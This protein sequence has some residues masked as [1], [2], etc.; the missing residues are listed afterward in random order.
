MPDHPLPATLVTTRL[1]RP[2]HEDEFAR[3]ADRFDEAACRGPGTEGSLRLEQPGGMHHFVHRFPSRPELDRWLG[4]ED[5]R[6]LAAEADRYSV[7]RGEVAEGERRRASLPSEAAVPKWKTWVATWV[8]VF[9][10]LLALNAAVGVA[11]GGLPE[12]V[13]LAITSLV[14]TAALT[15]FLLPRIKKWLR[16]WLFADVADRSGSQS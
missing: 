12:P 16:P 1:V 7:G 10:L 6:A 11:A 15:W 9:P 5:Y 8:T 4:G 2:G 3:W 13:R 14:M